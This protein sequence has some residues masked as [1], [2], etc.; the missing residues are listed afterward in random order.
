MNIKTLINLCPAK[1]CFVGFLLFFFNPLFSQDCTTVNNIGIT[2]SDNDNICDLYDLDDD[3]DGIP[4]T[5]EC[6][7]PDIIL[8]GSFELGNLVPPNNWGLIHDSNIVG[9]NSSLP[10]RLIEYWGRNFLGITAP[11]GDIIVELNSTAPSAIYQTI[12]VNPGDQILWSLNHKGRVGIDRASVRIG[13][14]FATA[15]VQTIMETDRFTFEQYAGLYTVPAGQT[16]TLFIIESV[17]TAGNRPSV[18]NLIDNVQIFLIRNCPDFDGDGIPNDQDLDSD[19]DGVYDVVESG[20]D[21][22]NDDGRAD[23]DDNNVDNS[24]T[25]GIP[26]SAGNG[27]TPIDT[28]ND[29]TPDFL[30]LDS[31]ADGCSDADEAYNDPDADGNDTGV[32]GVDPATVDSN[33]LVIGAPY[34]DPFVINRPILKVKKQVLDI[35]GIDITGGA[36]NPGDQLFYEL[37]IEN[38]GNEDIINASIRDALPTNVIFNTGSIT[39][40]LGLN[41]SY[42]SANHE[43]NITIDDEQIERFDGP[44]SIRFGVNVVSSCADLRDACSNEI[45]N[46]AVS[47]YTGSVSNINITNEDSV[48]AQDSCLFDIEGASTVTIDLASC[49]GNFEAFICTGSI[50]LVAGSGFSTYVWTNL[51]T[52][53]TVG[54]NQTLTV[55]TGGRYRVDKGGNPSC[56]DLFEIW[57]VTAFNTVTNPIIPIANDPNVNGNVRTCPITGDPLPELFL[58]GATDSI[59]LD[60]GFV[61]ANSIIWERLDPAACPTVPRNGDCPTVDGGCAADWTQVATTRDYTVSDAGE[62]RITTVF[63]G[64][65]TITFYFNVF[66]NNFEPNL[67][68]VRDIVCSTPGTLRVQNSSSQYE[69]QLV[70]PGGGTIGYQASPEFTGLTE[71]GTYTV[72]VRQNSGLSTACL[73][74]TTQF[75]EVLDSTVSITA[76]DP[77]CPG[78]RGEVHIQV[79]DGDAN[80]TYNISSATNPFTA[81]EG[82]T[83]NPNHTFTGLN[84]DTYNV[85]VLSY[86]GECID[87]QSITVDP[88]PVFSAITTLQRDLSC[89]V[90]YQPDPGVSSPPFDPDQFIALVEVNV[91]GGIGGFI[92][93]TN[94][95]MTPPLLTPEPSTS[96]VFRFTTIGTHTIFVQDTST[97]C[98][99]PAGSVVVSPYEEIQATL[100]AINPDCPGDDGSLFIQLIAGEGPFTYVLNSSTFV[101]SNGDH[102]FINIPVGNHSVQVIDRFGCRHPALNATVVGADILTAD[103]AITQEYRCD[104]SGSSVTPQLGEITISNPQ[105][106][107]GSYEYSI[108]GVDFTNTTGIFT[109]LTDGTY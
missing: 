107:N 13:N 29:G 7:I 81:S 76:T 61:D 32:Y 37:E 62:Y 2:D 71:G 108:D 89:N 21:D 77:G 48:L 41:G 56:N 55:S 78:G 90:N 57:T 45:T 30:N 79:T 101:S 100:T 38:Q 63:D 47:S 15:P 73:F 53:A 11:E 52:G 103:I 106:G 58:C 18:G 31:D 105:N 102:T 94:S 72:N 49:D 51:D 28:G 42:N 96:N 35:N 17:S 67:V 93:G 26:T 46:I 5:V 16:N 27:T 95:T 1:L 9:W 40:S 10:N 50:D 22:L 65:C 33:G 92:Y 109:G 64:N 23:D 44:T 24:T 75:M 12:N 97:G 39:G 25:K 70:T 69:Y 4:D 104:A 87:T 66:K 60:S 91:T 36:V 84:I 80:Y 3:N 68:I 88:S 86:D 14:N 85:E 83:T 98:I 99:I 6:G 43:V 20:G 59:Y 74:T 8:N 82:P 19:N 34:T 54:T